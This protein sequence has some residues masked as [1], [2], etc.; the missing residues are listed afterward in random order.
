MYVVKTQVPSHSKNFV[1]EPPCD[2][3]RDVAVPFT[4]PQGQEHQ[5][6][7]ATALHNL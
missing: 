7:L 2:S 4:D 6:C 5:R 3:R 1:Y